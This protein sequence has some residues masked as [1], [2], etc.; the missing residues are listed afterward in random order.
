M[1]AQRDVVARVASV[2]VLFAGVC[3]GWSNARIFDNSDALGDFRDE[4]VAHA[5]AQPASPDQQGPRLCRDEWQMMCE[6]HDF[7]Q[8]G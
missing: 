2:D 5:V 6:L 8:R 7:A 3:R 1:F 4:R